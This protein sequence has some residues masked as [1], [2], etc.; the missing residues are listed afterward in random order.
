MTY[1]QW[2][3]MNIEYEDKLLERLGRKHGKISK[4]YKK[5]LAQV[6]DLKEELISNG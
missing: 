5:K 3:L 6:N 1:Q 2:V 4:Q